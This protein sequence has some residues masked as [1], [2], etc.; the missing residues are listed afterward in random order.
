MVNATRIWSDGPMVGWIMLNPSTADATTEDP[1]SRR[2][3]AFSRAWGYGGLVVANLYAYRATN[4][5]DLWKT[6][7]PI[8]PD[9]NARLTQTAA[10]CDLV[11][12]AWGVNARFDRI[13]EVLALPG[14]DRLAALGVTKAGQPRHPLYLPGYFT[15]PPYYGLRDYGIEGQYGLE[16]TPA[17]YV[18]TMR[19]VFTE[20]RRV[21]ADDGTLR[22]N[23]GDSYSAGGQGGNRG[24]H[25]SGG[26]H[27]D[28][29]PMPTRVPGFA[30][31]NLLGMP[32]RVAFALQDG[33]WVLRND[34]IWHKPNA[35][36]ESVTDRMSKRHEHVFLLAKSV[37]YWFDLDEVR[38]PH[39]AVSVA[40]SERR[41]RSKTL[42]RDEGV[43]GQKFHNFANA[44]NACG[45]NPGDIWSIPT[46]P[47]PQAHFATFPIDLPL[48]CIRAGCKPGGTV[49]DPFSGSGTTGQ[50]A[51]MLGRRYVGIDLNPAYHDLAVQRFAQG[52]LDFE[53]ATSPR[54]PGGVPPPPGP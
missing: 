10:A 48:R 47:F 1:T 33:G 30:P 5:L 23:L 17:E 37:R 13:A 34:I 45:A 20:V 27:L 53:T 49:L 16:E 11:V 29:V 28:R 2:V 19:R 35:M 4:P 32:W 6:P 22:L 51:R 43:S 36:P 18:E 42:Y 31:K 54:T 25:L 41:V 39:T 21:L 9:N 44:V 3:T 52:V 24:G 50:A 15:S 14:M 12:A 26:P 7:D 46:R 40:S 8:G 38:E